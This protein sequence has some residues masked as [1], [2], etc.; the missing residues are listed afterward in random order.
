MAAM[1]KPWSQYQQVVVE[2]YNAVKAGKSSRIHVRP[3]PGTAVS[4]VDGCRMFALDAEAVPGG[5]A[6]PYLRKG[7]G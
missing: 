5:H 6:L 4:T 7:D 3:V 1:T 2:T